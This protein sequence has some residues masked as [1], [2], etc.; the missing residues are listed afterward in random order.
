MERVNRIARVL[1]EDC[2]LMPGERVLLCGADRG[3]TVAAWFAVLKAGGI[4]VNMPP[5][6]LKKAMNEGKLQLAICHRRLE[7]DLTGASAS[8]TGT[9]VQIRPGDIVCGVGVHMAIT[10]GVGYSSVLV[11]DA[12]PERL[13]AA[14]TRFRATVCFSTAS[15]YGR[16]A[17]LLDGYDISSLRAC[18]ANGNGL[19]ATVA[20]AWQ[21]KPGMGLISLLGPGVRAGMPLPPR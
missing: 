7:I 3:L 15:D 21:L 2:D 6:L 13:L 19:P 5:G 8:S 18:V 16:M 14:M 9:G 10:M 20:E 1:V 11:E 17:D 12:T 4:A